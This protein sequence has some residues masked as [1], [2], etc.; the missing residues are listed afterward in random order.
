MFGNSSW[1]VVARAV[2]DERMETRSHIYHIYHPCMSCLSLA[3]SM[4][5]YAIHYPLSITYLLS[6][7][8]AHGPTALPPANSIFKITF[9]SVLRSALSIRE[10]LNHGNETK[11]RENK[12]ISLSSSKN[13]PSSSLLFSSLTIDEIRYVDKDLWTQMEAQLRM[14]GPTLHSSPDRLSWHHLRLKSTYGSPEHSRARIP[15]SIRICICIWVLAQ[16]ALVAVVNDVDARHYA[17]V[18]TKS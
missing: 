6:L 10:H 15:P 9:F 7:N 1:L 12:R 17:D 2:G 3:L 4:Q 18:F 13:A 16:S 14:E 8:T 11:M 5:P